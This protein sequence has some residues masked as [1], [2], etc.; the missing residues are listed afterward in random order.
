MIVGREALS[1]F[2]DLRE[3]LVTLL[4]DEAKPTRG[5]DLSE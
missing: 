4:L 1:S 3:L 2:T 5:D